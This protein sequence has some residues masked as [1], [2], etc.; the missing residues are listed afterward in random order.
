MYIRRGRVRR[1]LWRAAAFLFA[2]ALLLTAADRRLRP[3]VREYAANQARVLMGEAMTAAVNAALAEGAY[4]Y[5][6]LTQVTRS[7]SGA[8][9]SIEANAAAVNRLTADVVTA[10]N[11]TLAQKEYSTLKLPLLNATGS[12]FLMGRGPTVTVRVHQSSAATV[13]LSSEFASAGINQTSHRLELSLSFRA[14]V[15]AA[16]ASEPIEIESNF[17]VAETVI[18][19]AVPDVFANVSR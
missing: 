9:L 16:G 6:E 19:G 2:A 7:E 13:R 17:L 4:G 3:V 5:D 18:V 1:W 14:T 10:L 15:L 12:V 8:V 11:R